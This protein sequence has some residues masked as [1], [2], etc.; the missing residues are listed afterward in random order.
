MPESVSGLGDMVAQ[1]EE[2]LETCERG[3]GS[4]HYLTQGVG[5]FFE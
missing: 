1:N 2:N 3:L 4:V 5:E